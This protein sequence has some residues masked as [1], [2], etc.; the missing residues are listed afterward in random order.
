MVKRNRVWK[1]VVVVVFAHMLAACSSGARIGAMTV[2]VSPD[3]LITSSSPA[4]KAITI[5][6]VSGGSE[7]NPLWLSKVSNENFQEALQQSLA[8]HAMAADKPGRYWLTAELISLNQ[9]F[10]GF[11]MTVTAKVHYVLSDTTGQPPRFDQTIET[12]YTANFSDNFLAAE[13]LRLANEG[14]VRENIEKAIKALLGALQSP[15]APRAGAGMQSQ[16]SAWLRLF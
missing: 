8:L 7:T 3:T 5:A 1:A 14:A 4:F 16:A 13:R 6:N 12:P 15:A 11:D 10:A 9:P 2:P